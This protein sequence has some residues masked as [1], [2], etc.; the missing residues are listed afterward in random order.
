MAVLSLMHSIFPRKE[1]LEKCRKMYGFTLEKCRK[2][3]V[4]TL[5][6]CR[7]LLC[8]WSGRKGRGSKIMIILLSYTNINKLPHL[9]GCGSLFISNQFVIIVQNVANL[10]F[11][12]FTS[13]PASMSL[14]F[15]L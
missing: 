6:K 1:F 14:S 2:R 3:G 4:F 7:K 11:V 5:V 10:Q 13:A 15:L 9:N 8:S 12:S